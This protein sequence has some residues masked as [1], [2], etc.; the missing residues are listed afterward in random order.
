MF[1]I[2]IAVFALAMGAGIWLLPNSAAAPLPKERDVPKK[3]PNPFDKMFPD[4]LTVDFGAL[5][6]GVILKGSFRIVNTM[7]VPLTII[8]RQTWDGR[9]IFGGVKHGQLEPF[10]TAELEFIV[11]TNKFV[12]PKTRTIDVDICFTLDHGEVRT[13][14]CVIS[15]NSQDELRI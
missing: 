6:R 11:D 4:G 8:C 2:K 7:N 13:F 3:A 15:A 1:K 5:K 9:H 14:E 12:G 10:E